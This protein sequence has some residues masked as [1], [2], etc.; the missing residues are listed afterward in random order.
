MP[1]CPS[2]KHA[3]EIQLLRMEIPMTPNPFA[4]KPNAERLYSALLDHIG[5]SGPWTEEPKKSSV[6]I[7]AG[8]GAFLGVHP[9]AGGLLLNIVLDRALD[10]PRLSKVEQVSRSRYHNEVVVKTEDEIDAELLAWIG[11]AYQLKTG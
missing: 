5:R 9:R 8:R 6:H 3:F 2:I 4:G 7:A 11:E 10:S 1:P